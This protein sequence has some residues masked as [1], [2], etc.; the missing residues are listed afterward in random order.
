[1]TFITKQ[2]LIKFGK[3]RA[4]RGL[5]LLQ[6]QVTL[7]HKVRQDHKAHKA[8]KVTLDHKVPQAHKVR[9]VRKVTQV[10]L[11]LLAHRERQVPQVHKVQRGPLEV[12]RAVQGN[13]SLTVE[14]NS[15]RVLT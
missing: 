13:C 8:H 10:T 6:L 11:E 7:D 4:G 2:T 3:T 9:K 15:Q 1:M 5:I 12:L 14:H